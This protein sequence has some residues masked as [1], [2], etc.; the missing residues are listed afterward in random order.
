MDFWTP[1][2]ICLNYHLLQPSK[3]ST[4]LSS[5]ESRPEKSSNDQPTLWKSF[6]KIGNISGRFIQY[7][8]E[9][10]GWTNV[11]FSAWTPNP[12]LLPSPSK[13]VVSNFYRFGTFIFYRIAT[14][15]ILPP[16][17]GTWTYLN[18]TFM[19]HRYR[20]MAP[21]SVKTIWKSYAN[22]LQRVNWY[23][24]KIS[25]PSIRTVFVVKLWP[26]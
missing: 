19:C 11:Y 10:N 6:S 1:I 14:M 18:M 9:H 8:F 15:I 5:I 2:A 20:I 26:V 25:T 13:M 22:V 7:Y 16:R 12:R 23:N 24:S 3:S 4:K 17:I 21:E